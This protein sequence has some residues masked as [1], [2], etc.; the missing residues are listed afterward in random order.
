MDKP[1]ASNKVNKH[2]KFKE[3]KVYSS[4]EWLA[5]N[6][7][8]YRQVFDRY[9]TT[10][11][12]VELSFYNKLFD[13]ESWK[14]NINLKCFE[15]KNGKKAVCSLD[16][17]RKINKY[18]N[19]V[20]IREGWG[21]KKEGLFWKKG[22]YCWEA[23]ID[24]KKVG[25]K[26]FYIEDTGTEWESVESNPYF[27][28]KSVR[29]YEGKYDDVIEE[30][31]KYLK[32]M[33]S[34]ETRYVYSEIV[35][36][37]NFIGKD[38]FLELFVK[39]YNEARELKGQVVKLQ[40]VG[41]DD[42]LIKIS[43]GW[44]SNTPGSWRFG[45][46]IVD[47]IFLNTLIASV[48]FEVDDQFIEG[49]AP[50]VLSYKDDSYLSTSDLVG[51]LTFEEVVAKLDNLIGLSQIKKKVKEHAQYIQ[52]LKL[53]K[54]K[55]F[56]EEERINIHSVFIGNPG[57]GKTTVAKMMGAIYHK[58]GLL[59]KGHVH[60]VDRV[61]LVGEYIGQTAPKVK[62]ALEKA[63][64]GVLFIDEAYSLARSNDDSKDF[65]R[66]VIEMLV[67]E[68]SSGDLDMAIIVAGYPKEM[69]HFIESNPGLK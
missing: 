25:V 21:N 66:E 65:G 68:M 49:Q 64:G 62:E 40:S 3:L 46:Y 30:E 13:Q 54:E 5:D 11:V 6:K 44:G 32:S 45:N 43:A 7:K 20:Y 61:D 37:N 10:Y 56:E 28:L 47:I 38:W 9:E 26:Y 60:E 48:P 8:K 2:F 18:D 42:D 29:L 23:W 15:I 63:R 4:T 52:F 55:G 36:E 53:R 22:N 39:Y 51:N 12:Y 57:T 14:V 50:V 27:N 67:K 59:S 35:L 1:S 41:K 31:R 17:S 19:I 58:M 16:F 34:E 24:G 69:K 33:S